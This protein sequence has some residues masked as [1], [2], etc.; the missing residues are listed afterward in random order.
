MYLPVFDLNY[1]LFTDGSS[2]R[3]CQDPV[4]RWVCMDSTE[5]WDKGIIDNHI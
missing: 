4:N 5:D 2:G 3:Q 1:A